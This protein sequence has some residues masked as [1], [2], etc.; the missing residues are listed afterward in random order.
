MVAKSELAVLRELGWLSLTAADFCQAVLERLSL[1]RFSAGQAIFRAGD[2][3]G[4]L[5]GLVD[6]TVQVDLLGPQRTPNLAHFGSP[7]YWFGEGP[8]IFKSPRRITVYANRPSTLAS[9]SLSDCRDLLES[10]PASWRWIALLAALSSDLAIDAVAGLLVQDPRQRVVG[11][12][13]RLSGHRLG[14][15]LPPAPVPI[16]TSQQELAR[17]ANLSRTVVSGILR[18]L[19]KERLVRLHYRRMEVLDKA[20]LERL[21]A[22]D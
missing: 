13:L 16:T 11:I 22:D 6:G 4:G 17:I 19:E 21:L 3:P 15:L 18:E 8:L 2:S 1:R 12:L 14:S 5:W 10:D 20:G 7:G 9:L